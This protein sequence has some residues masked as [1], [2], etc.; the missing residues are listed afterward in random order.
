MMSNC[1]KSTDE[2]LSRYL[3]RVACL[4]R[5]LY[6]LLALISFFLFKFFLKKIY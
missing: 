2:D 4:P 3:A 1:A 5:G 6:V